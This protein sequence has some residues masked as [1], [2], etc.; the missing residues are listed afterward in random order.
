MAQAV[1]FSSDAIGRCTQVLTLDGDCDKSAALEAERRI[2][3]ALG[4]GKSEIIVDLRGLISIDASMLHVLFRG[5]VRSSARDG[6]LLII[7]PNSSVWSAFEL[8]GLHRAFP[9]STDLEDAL[10]GTSR[11][12]VAA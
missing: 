12:S 9:N 1:C 4:A 10:A 3:A 8:S 5:L 11:A 6:N 2:L 7:R